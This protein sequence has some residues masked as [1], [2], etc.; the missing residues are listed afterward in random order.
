MVRLYTEVIKLESDFDRVSAL[1]DWQINFIKPVL[2]QINPKYYE[3][4]YIEL[5]AELAK[6]LANYFELLLIKLDKSSSKNVKKINTIGK[7][8]I[9]SWKIISEYFYKNGENNN[10]SYVNSLYN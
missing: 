7:E 8:S 2:S 1:Y 10:E 5:H 4:L 9:D 6:L 3:N